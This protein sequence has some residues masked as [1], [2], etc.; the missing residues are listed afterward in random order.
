MT[1]TGLSRWSQPV[2]TAWPQLYSVGHKTRSYKF[3]KGS[4][5]GIDRDRRE[6]RVGVNQNALY[7]CVKLSKKAKIPLFI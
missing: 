3:G 6:I 2:A 4:R 5:R 7:T 1:P